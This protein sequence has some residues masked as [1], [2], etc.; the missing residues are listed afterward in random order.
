M[1][2]KMFYFVAVTE[3]WDR[4][5]SCQQQMFVLLKPT[6]N[7]L[8]CDISSYFSQKICTL[9]QLAESGICYYC[10]STNNSISFGY[11]LCTLVVFLTHQSAHSKELQ[12][13]ITVHQLKKRNW[14]KKWSFFFVYVIHLIEHVILERGRSEKS[15]FSINLSVTSSICFD[16]KSDYK[17]SCYSR[18]Y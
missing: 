7:N 1:E 14:M 9:L 5:N 18:I 11:S 2:N 4:S 13:N 15:L 17:Q 12:K 10:Y 3:L 16:W 8:D 6:Q